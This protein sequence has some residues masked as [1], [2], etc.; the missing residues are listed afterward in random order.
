MALNVVDSRMP[1]VPCVDP[2]VAARLLV[3]L[4]EDQINKSKVAYQ[5]IVIMPQP[6]DTKARKELAVH[7]SGMG[8]KLT[9]DEAHI[10]FPSLAKRHYQ[11]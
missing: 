5:G 9:Y 10:H 6:G 11:K 7:V 8:R 4:C 2:A 3:V 1:M